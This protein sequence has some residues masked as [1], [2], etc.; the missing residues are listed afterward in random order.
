MCH[1]TNYRNQRLKQFNKFFMLI[2]ND[3][4]NVE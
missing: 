3:L 1:N 4:N 2:R